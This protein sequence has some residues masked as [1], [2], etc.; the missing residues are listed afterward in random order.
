MTPGRGLLKGILAV[1]AAA[2]V[3][4]PLPLPLPTPSLL[5]TA[6]PSPSLP[7][8]IPTPSPPSLATPALPPT[9]VATPAQ[10]A[11]QGGASPGGAAAGAAKSSPA[12]AHGP[13]RGVAIPFTAIYVSSPTDVALLVALAVLPLLLGV[14]LLL[15]GRTLFHAR[16]LREAHIRLMLAADLGL[17][18]KDMTSMSTKAL[19]GLREK[20]A[21]DELTG[22]LRRAAG[23][24]VTEREIARAGRHNSPL[25]LAFLDIDGLDEINDK[26]GRATGDEM[27]RG[28][29]HLLKEG[30]R[31]D[32]AVLRY[33]GDEFVCILP[34]MAA[35]QARAKLGEI[36]LEAA[37][38][39]IRFAI[40]VAE[41]QRSDDVVSL[42]ARADTD[43]YEFKVSRGEIVQ[44][45]AD[46][47]KR[48]SKRTVSV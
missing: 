19:F 32:D 10:G 22:V 5:P 13:T 36:Q 30:L 6:L 16:R 17:R 43:L 28:L 39:G 37:R 27:L 46:G 34:D 23:I 31:A 35:K 42:L 25:T 47:V 15:F 48:G 26:E 9:A 40:G 20:S 18:P 2:L 33:G 12:A 1:A 24:S 41:L 29:T 8:L 38:Q 14:W 4:L 45:P 44:L 21:F 7:S 11:T 3:G